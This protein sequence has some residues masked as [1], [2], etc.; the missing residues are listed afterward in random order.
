MT[1]IDALAQELGSLLN[2]PFFLETGGSYTYQINHDFLVQL[3]EDPA[4]L[5]FLGSF[6]VSL[7]VGKFRENVL[8][9]A[10]KA[11][12]LLNEPSFFA[13]NE[14]QEKLVLYQSFDFSRISA[15]KLLEAFSLFV[16][17]ALKWKE[18]I[19]KGQNGP[20]DFLQKIAT[21]K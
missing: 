15:E 5:L 6:L 13:F 12:Y 19:D 1:R 3:E 9:S 4:G 7:P 21:T 16:E 8:A 20:F 2:L 10:M 11:N 17:K 18:A 14:K